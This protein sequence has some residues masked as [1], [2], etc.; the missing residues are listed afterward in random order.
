[1]ALNSNPRHRKCSCGCGER[2]TPV[3]P[4]QRAATMKCAIRIA[5]AKRE[6]EERMEWRKRKMAAKPL[7]WWKAKAQSAVNAYVRERDKEDVCISCGR[8]HDG[9]WHAGHYLSVGSRPELRFDRDNIHKQCRPCNEMK[10]GNIAEYRPRLIAKIGLD[11]VEALEG[12]H[13]A[14]HFT[15]EDCQR[16]EAEFKAKLKELRKR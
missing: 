1:M 6:K 3:R 12:P 8:W 4:L 14:A 9:Q 15:R 7:S 13:P 5:K 10:S 11:R 16:I 2:F